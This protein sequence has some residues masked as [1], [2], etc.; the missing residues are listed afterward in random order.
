[1]NPTCT[2]K[3]E[4]VAKTRERNTA[5]K[6]AGA[7]PMA[8][9]RSDRAAN[10]VS[11]AKRAGGRIKKALEVARMEPMECPAKALIDSARAGDPDAI[12]RADNI[13]G[14]TWRVK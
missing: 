3:A 14:K 5:L 8:D 12:R 6:A 11:A 4:Q 1:V 2:I 7:A 9:G 13:Y 10:A